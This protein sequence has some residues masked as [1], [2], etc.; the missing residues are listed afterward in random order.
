MVNGSSTANVVTTGSFTIPLM[1]Q[2]GYPGEKAAAVE[3]AASTNGQLMPPIMG[4]AAF[5][6]AEFLG[7]GYLD[8]VKAAAIPAFCAYLTLFYIVHLEALKLGMKGAPKD[9]IPLFFVT[10]IR[11]THFL[12]PVIFLIGGLLWMQ[13]SPVSA[14]YQA[15]GVL[16]AIM[17]AQHPIRALKKRTSM[18]PA[19]R[20]GMS[21]V[22]DGIVMGARNMIPIGVA[23]AAAGIVVGTVTLTGQ[24]MNAVDI[25]EAFSMG[26]LALALII[27]ALTCMILGMGLPTTANYIVMAT[28]V[29]PVI[30][31]LG[32]SN[33]LVVPLIAAHL[34]VFFFGIL[35]DVTPP[36]AL[37]AYAASGIAG[38]DPIKTGVQALIYDLRTAILPFMFIFNTEI[39]L[40]GV[41][42]F[43]R[44]VM[45]F[46]LTLGGMFAFAAATQ[47]FLFKRLAY[48]ERA[49][50]LLGALLVVNPHLFDHLTGGAVGYGYAFVGVAIFAVV[51]GRQYV[52]TRVAEV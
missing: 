15:I 25:V 18:A 6:I 3:V 42:S 40:V 9:L 47:G 4:A 1:K 19:F 21:E 46:L 28:L 44:G 49:A 50:L 31:S 39:L 23:T 26:S 27:T 10:F 11:G 22:Y 48:V 41:D 36:V 34:F 16:V 30:V 52:V 45:V 29:A 37:A 20:Q 5:I 17:L 2:V 38:S 51:V 14:V 13:L 33:G 32:A 7:I 8:V 35:A 43:W 12:L 24:G